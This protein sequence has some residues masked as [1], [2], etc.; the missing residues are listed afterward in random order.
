MEKKNR[1]MNAAMT[2][3]I[4]AAMGIV[5]SYLVLKTNPQAAA[6]TPPPVMYGSNLILS[7]LLGCVSGLVLPFGRWGRSL[8][9]KARAKPPGLR[10]TLLNSLPLAAGNT[11][12]ISLILSFVGVF[13][14]RRGVPAEA[15]AHMPPLLVMWLGSWANLLLPTLLV[16]YLLAVLLSPVLA[17]LMGLSGPAG[18]AGGA[19][20]SRR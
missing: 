18:G 19:G 2:V 7:I 1:L 15:L 14:A 20:P 10:F 11:V 3:L 17:R 12:I 5:A 8:A 13:M 6:A 9:D 16:S 4:S